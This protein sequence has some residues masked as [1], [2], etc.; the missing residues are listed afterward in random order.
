MLLFFISFGNFEKKNAT[1]YKDELDIYIKCFSKEGM[2]P[3]DIVKKKKNLR[4]S[5]LK[6]TVRVIGN[7]KKKAKSKDRKIPF[8]KELEKFYLK[9]TLKK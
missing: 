5:V 8:S 7:N 2:S 3:R 1:M 6:S 4:I 9:K